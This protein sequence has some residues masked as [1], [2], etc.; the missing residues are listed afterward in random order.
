MIPPIE[1]LLT[2]APLP[3]FRIWSSSYFMQFQTPLRLIE[4]TRSNS[5]PLASAVSAIGLCTPALLNAASS[6][7]KV[8]TV[9]TT[10]A[11]TWLS[12]LTS[13]RIASA[14]CPTATIS[15]AAACTDSS[16]LSASTT[17]APASANAFAVARPM[18]EPAPVTSATL[19]S[20]DKFMTEFLTLLYLYLAYPLRIPIRL[21][22]Q[23]LFDSLH[24]T[25]LRSIHVDNEAVARLLCDDLCPS[26]VDL[27]HQDLR[28]F[29]PDLVDRTEI[30]HLL[31]FP[32]PS[33]YGTRN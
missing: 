7:P 22:R 4:L 2:M 24:C 31:S 14:L 19:F 23:G 29:W 12:S 3:C 16:L 15:L 17:E 6:L 8:D 11:A 13:Q 27:G 28:D 20:N 21:T 9:C 10:M 30:D 25:L 32:N 33:G 26:V 5:S 1:E 18:P